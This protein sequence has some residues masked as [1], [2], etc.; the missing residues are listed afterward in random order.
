VYLTIPQIKIIIT[1]FRT[2]PYPFQ[3]EICQTIKAQIYL[4][5]RSVV[6]TTSG[7]QIGLVIPRAT[8]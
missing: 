2:T 5:I 6:V 4:N 8:A 7:M 3:H 1:F